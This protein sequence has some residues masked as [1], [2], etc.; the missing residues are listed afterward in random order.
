MTGD[1]DN[2]ELITSLLGQIEYLRRKNSAKS[3]IIS[4]LLNNN[5]VL[6]NNK[7]KL[8]NI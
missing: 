5:K 4:N 2:S 1:D 3:G 6:L 7:E 8:S